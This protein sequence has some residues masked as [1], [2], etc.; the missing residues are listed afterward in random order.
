MSE[1]RITEEEIAWLRTLTANA[2]PAPWRSMIEGRNHHAGDSFIMIGRED[3]RDEDLY[4]TRDSG[5]ASSADHDLV[6][7]A[8]NY[9]D[10]LLDEI[11]FLRAELRRL[12]HE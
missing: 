11:E 6:A 1:E 4:L 8:R 7:A 3:D 12:R 10:V 2:S 5:P 9:I